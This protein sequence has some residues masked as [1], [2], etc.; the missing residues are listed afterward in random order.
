MDLDI[1]YGI[2]STHNK[3]KDNFKKNKYTIIKKA[4]SKELANFL[5]SYFLIKRDAVKYMYSKDLIIKHD[6][7]GYWNDPQCPNVYVNYGD[8]AMDTL[9]INLLSLMEEQTK[10]SLIPTY[11]FARIYE[12]G[13]ILHRHKDR[14]SCEI[15]TTLNLGGDP[16]PIFI[17]PT[18]EDNIYN[19]RSTEKGEECDI[20][21]DAHKGIE[22]NL[23]PGDMLIYRG[24]EL[25][26]WRKEFKGNECVQVFLHYNEMTGKFKDNL[27]DKRPMLGLPYGTK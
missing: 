18:G 19:L 22:V 12:K 9:L 23:N 2:I 16:W 5:C 7:L 8:F 17:D 21:E 10:L 13:S 4:I 27:Y 26:H 1:L 20:L 24:Y 6:L 25:E 3:M 11:S 14:P 15:S